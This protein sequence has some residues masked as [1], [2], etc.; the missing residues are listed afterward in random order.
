MA[1]LPL[2]NINFEVKIRKMKAMIFASGYGS[3]LRP[4]TDVCPKALLEVGGVPLLLRVLRNLLV[5]HPSEV[6]V[7]VHHLGDMIA[8]A[9]LSWGEIGASVRVSYE[10]DALLD[11]GGGLL[12]AFS[13]SEC[14][15]VLAHNVDILSNADLDVLCGAA[16]DQDAVLLVSDRISNRRL[17]FDEDMRMVGWTNVKTGEVRSPYG[18]IDVSSLHSLAFSGIQIIGPG[19]FR[20]MEGWP[21]RFGIMDFYI[22][23]CGRL[24]I[25]GIVQENLRLLD[26]GKPESLHSAVDFLRGLGKDV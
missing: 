24:R 19:A 18:N 17:L 8:D 5:L 9:L 15:W 22:H 11:T 26:V 4:L 14:E 12:R 13:V 10:R 23:Q 2:E 25:K 16:S 20:A 6:V 21:E 7:N 1:K 3:R